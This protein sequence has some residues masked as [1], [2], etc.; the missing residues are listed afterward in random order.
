MPK[1]PSQASTAWHSPQW[2]QRFFAWAMATAAQG[3]ETKM[4]DRK[5]QL[6]AHLQGEVLEL[7]PGAGPNLTYFKPDIHWLGLEPNPYMHPYL[8]QQADELGLNIEVQT[9][10]LADIAISDNSKDVVLCTLVLCSVPDLESTVQDILRV[11]KP[12]GQFLFIEHVMAPAGSFL[13]QVQTGLCPLWQ[14]IGDG[15]R[16]D[17]ETGKV[18]ESAGFANVDYQTF[19]APVPIA[20]VKPHIMGVATKAS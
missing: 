20:V 13:R 16:L 8:Q 14:V 3:Y 19:E 12:G 15:C 18:I 2:Y 1:T 11:L 9:T 10:T 4:A 6:F 5:Q 17:R 7:G